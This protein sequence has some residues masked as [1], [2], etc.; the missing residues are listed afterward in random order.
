MGQVSLKSACV[1]IVPQEF[2]LWRHIKKEIRFI[3]N[4]INFYV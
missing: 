2:S 1:L 4:K 3:E